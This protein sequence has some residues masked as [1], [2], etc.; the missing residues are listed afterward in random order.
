MAKT[1]KVTTNKKHNK[2]KRF[3]GGEDFSIEKSDVMLGI[4]VNRDEAARITKY[5]GHNT[6]NDKINKYLRENN[7]PIRIQSIDGTRGL[8]ILG[9]NIEHL[10]HINGP[11]KPLTGLLSELRHHRKNFKSHIKQLNPELKKVTLS[12]YEADP[13]T[14]EITINEL[15]PY[16][17]TTTPV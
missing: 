1:I 14:I 11:L 3:F 5:T 4:P 15:K 6:D 17:F 2:S 16:L 8:C 9:Y 10:S 7:T 12:L 13:D